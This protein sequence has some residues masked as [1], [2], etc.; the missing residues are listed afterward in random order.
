MKL[1]TDSSATPAHSAPLSVRA[2]A[3]HVAK[4]RPLLLRLARQTS[5]PLQARELRDLAGILGRVI[6]AIERVAILRETR[7][8]R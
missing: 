3:P 5:D 7:G 6:A 8:M 2:A 4:A 1:T